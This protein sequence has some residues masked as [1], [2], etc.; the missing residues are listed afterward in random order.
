MYIFF[1]TSENVTMGGI[2]SLSLEI[3]TLSMFFGFLEERSF[4]FWKQV[5]CGEKKMGLQDQLS[6]AE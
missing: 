1:M 4:T 5:F 2:E 3:F 6:L